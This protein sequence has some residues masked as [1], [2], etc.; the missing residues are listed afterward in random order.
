MEYFLICCAHRDARRNRLAGSQVAN[1]QW[2][3]AAGDLN[4]N[5]MAFSEAVGSR[6][7]IDYDPPETVL[8]SRVQSRFQADNP[9]ADVN[10]LS[11]FARHIT[12]PDEE[13]GVLGRRPNIQL[14]GYRAHNRCIM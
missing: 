14:C 8:V 2:M 7:Q 12:Q 5:A 9:V 4:A 10:R 1:V 11:V 6:E 3:A 13:V